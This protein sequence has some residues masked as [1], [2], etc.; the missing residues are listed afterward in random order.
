[1]RACESVCKMVVRINLCVASSHVCSECG[2]HGLV[3]VWAC[4]WRVLPRPLVGVSCA[5]VHSNCMGCC[6]NA[7]RHLT[8][9][10]SHHS[11][12]HIKTQA[13][14]FHSVPSQRPGTDHMRLPQLKPEALPLPGRLASTHHG[15]PAQPFHLHPVI[16]PPCCRRCRRCC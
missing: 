11:P 16:W 14:L 6:D 3:C 7:V 12:C 2:G 5:P 1:V 10:G 9:P 13:A 4:W 8:L 15:W